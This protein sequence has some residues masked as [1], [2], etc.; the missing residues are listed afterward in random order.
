[1]FTLTSIE[2]WNQREIDDAIKYGKYIT[3]FIFITA[4]VGFRILQL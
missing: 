1:M 3:F 2:R 4:D